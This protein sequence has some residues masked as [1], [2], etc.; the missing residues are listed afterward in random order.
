MATRWVENV[1][2]ENDLQKRGI[3]FKAGVTIALDKIDWAWSS[4]NEGRLGERLDAER[5]SEIAVNMAEGVPMPQILVFRRENGMYG[6]IGGFHR[7]NGAKEAKEKAVVAIVAEIAPDAAPIIRRLG[8][9]DNRREGQR[10]TAREAIEHAVWEVQNYDSPIE[11][12]A[13]DYGVS[14]DRIREKIRVDNT[15]KALAEF[16]VS[17]S[18]LTDTHVDVLAR[19]DFNTKVMAAAAEAAITTKATASDIATLA[20][21]VRARKTEMQQVDAV[22]EFEKSMKTTR[23]Q[24]NGHVTRAAHTKLTQPFRALKSAIERFETA[25]NVPLEEEIKRTLKKDWPEMRRFLNALLG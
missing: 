25:A 23:P 22:A 15:R 20:K 12:V 13:R 17:D 9:V 8:F 4:K 11:E 21:Q 6:I 24:T 14:P 2:A 18:K 10:A 5:V 19:M 16:G 3:P 7:G 1:R